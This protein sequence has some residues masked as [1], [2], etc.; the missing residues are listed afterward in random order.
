[1]LLQTMS[2]IFPIIAK[3]A[4]RPARSSVPAR[5]Q[6]PVFFVTGWSL[7]AFAVVT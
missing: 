7:T 1:M 6:T 3:A 4:R 5:H 2:A